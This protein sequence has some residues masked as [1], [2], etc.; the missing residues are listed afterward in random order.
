MTCLQTVTWL[1]IASLLLGGCCSAQQSGSGDQSYFGAIFSE[2]ATNIKGGCQRTDATGTKPIKAWVPGC[3]ESFFH[4]NKG[5]YGSFENLPPGN[6]VALGAAF[7]DSELNL[8]H[9]RLNYQIDSQGSF[10]GSWTAGGLLTMKLSPAEPNKPTKPRV[11]VVQGPLPKHLPEPGENETKLLTNLYAFHTS[12]NQVAFY[13]VGPNTLLT[14]R[15]FFGF[16]E[17]VTG[18]NADYLLKYGFHLLGELNGRWPDVGGDHGQSSPSIEQ[19]YSEA[20]APGLTRQPGF[21]QL[22]EELEYTKHLGGLGD[23]ADFGL[24]ADLDYGVNFQQFVAPGDSEFS[25]RRLTVDVT[26]NL[27]LLK[28]FTPKKGSPTS[29]HFGTLQLRAWLCESI[30]PAG[31]SVPFYFQPTLGGGDI[32]KER[33]LASFPD[34][35]FRAPDAL[36]LRAQYEQPLPRFSF[37]G[38]IFRADAGKVGDTRG[39]IDLSHLRHSFGAG[40]TLRAGNFPYVTIMYAWAGGEGHHTFA[41]VNLSSISPNGGA[42]SLW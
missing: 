9:W 35:R 12:L 15:S 30:V 26:N 3:L 37:L 20:T 5:L 36:L 23:K 34:Y 33:T 13:G 8:K 22:G 11:V 18:V 32:N 28:K 21:L 10:N 31:N 29:E 17:T 19:I 16:R 7:K 24:D 38:L 1:G 42:A 2:E 41:D 40:V 25:F 14:N 27:N 39:D 4:G 6:S